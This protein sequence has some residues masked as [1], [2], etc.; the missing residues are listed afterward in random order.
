MADDPR[1]TLGFGP[2]PGSTPRTATAAHGQV[3]R[4]PRTAITVP[5]RLRYESFLD[6][7]ETQSVN[8]SRSGMFIQANEPLPVGTVLDFEFALAD[9]FALLRGKGE[10]VRVITSP[11]GLGIRFQ[12][13]DDASQ[14]LIDKIIQVNTEE[15][16]TSTVPLEFEEA[17]LQ[18]SPARP[19]RGATV[20]AAGVQFNASNLHI[21]I[22]PGTAGYFIN[23]PLLNIRL[24]GFVIPAQEEFQLGT[25]FTV[26]IND[27]YGQSIFSGQGKV[28]AKHE[29]R[30]GI[31]LVDADKDT[32]ARLQ[33]EIAKM[34]PR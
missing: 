26:T 32:L 15:G 24:G 10:V 23:N 27:F 11:L 6:F 13:L 16:K 25:M 22:H 4:A 34:G 17:P 29:M 20:M 19:L 31:R 18:P 3:A 33:A 7:V 8:I 1:K 28:V 5:V 14:K 9:G 30:L 2:H 12:Q 21:V